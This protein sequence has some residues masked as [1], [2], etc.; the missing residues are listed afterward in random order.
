MTREFPEVSRFVFGTGDIGTGTIS[1]KQEQKLIEY[2]IDNRLW[3]HS[4]PFLYITSLYP[5]LSGP[6][7]HTP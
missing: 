5:V 6:A 7:Q 3:L 4:A 2:A 1:E